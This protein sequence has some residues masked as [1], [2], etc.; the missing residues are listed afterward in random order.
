MPTLVFNA[1]LSSFFVV[2]V[3][4]GRWTQNPHYLA[5]TMVASVV[6][7]LVLNSCLPGTA[8]SFIYGNIASFTG[9]WFGLLLY[10]RI[11]GMV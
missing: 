8:D 4:K 10:D 3:F 5:V 2:R 7:L 9:A 11:T 1:L 6:A